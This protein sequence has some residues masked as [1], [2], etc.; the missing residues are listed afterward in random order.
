MGDRVEDFIAQWGRVRPDLD[1]APMAVVGR[2]SR[3]GELLGPAIRANFRTHGLQSGEFDT[4]AT[5]RRAG[6]P[7]TLTPGQLSRTSMVTGAAMT[8]R[9]QRLEDRGLLERSTDPTNR[10]SVRVRL[11]EAGLALVDEAVVSHL[12]TERELL[13]RA[14]T[15]REQRQ[16][17]ALLARLLERS[18]DTADEG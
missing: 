11:T 9:L 12:A 1:V 5:L 14:L 6:E 16:L 13:D 7:Y 8:N 4:L 18:G 15:A 17:A 10:R 3:A 2:L